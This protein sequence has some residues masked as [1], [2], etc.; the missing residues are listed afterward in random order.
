MKDSPDERYSFQPLANITVN[1]TGAVNDSIQIPGAHV[2]EL[3]GR[4]CVLMDPADQ[5]II[6]DGVVGIR[7][8]STAVFRG[9]ASYATCEIEGSTNGKNITG[10][11]NFIDRVYLLCFINVIIREI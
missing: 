11:V 2:E 3:I 9:N 1:S 8:G 5:R 7:N 10:R 6:A 4:K